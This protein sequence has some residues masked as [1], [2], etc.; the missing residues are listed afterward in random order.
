MD[1][2]NLFR[3]ITK[4]SAEIVWIDEHYDMVKF[5]EVAKYG[6]PSGVDFGL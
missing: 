1:T 3:P 2:V 5:Q 6:R 4:F